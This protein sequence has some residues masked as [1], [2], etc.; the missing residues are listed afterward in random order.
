MAFRLPS[1]FVN[2]LNLEYLHLE[3]QLAT[4]TKYQFHDQSIGMITLH[5]HI[6]YIA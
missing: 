6:L 2:D 1:A 5:S 4:L 3:C